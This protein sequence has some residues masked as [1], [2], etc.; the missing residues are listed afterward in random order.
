MSNRPGARRYVRTAS[1]NS[2]ASRGVVFVLPGIMG[3]QLWDLGS[4]P[5]R[6][7]IEPKHI[8]GGR[9]A[10]LELDSTGTDDAQSGVRI[11]SNGVI[12]G[13][14]GTL[15]R[16]LNQNDF[17][18]CAFD[19]DWR[20]DLDTLAGRLAEAVES[21]GN[22]VPI[23]I[24]AH[25]MGGLVV[26]TV[27]ATRPA[28]ASRIQRLVM[29]GT[30]NF[31][32]Y[33][34][35]Q[36]FTGQHTFTKLVAG[37]DL[38]NRREDLIRYFATFPGLVAMLPNPDRTE[39]GQPQFFAAAT[40]PE[41]NLSQARLDR[42][43]AEQRRLDS[44]MPWRDRYTLIVGADRR[45]PARAR[46]NG[47]RGFDFD[48]RD[49]DG[50]VPTSLCL[51]PGV[52]ATHFTRAEH[53]AMPSDRTVI[54][55]I[56][57]VLSGSQVR[58]ARSAGI[59]RVAIG[60]Q[61]HSEP[62]I[63]IPDFI[64]ECRARVPRPR[65][66]RAT[67][68]TATIDGD[69]VDAIASS[70]TSD[71]EK[72][73]EA[74]TEE[75]LRSFVMQAPTVRTPRAR[76][77]APVKVEGIAQRR[78]LLVRSCLGSIVD[79]P[80]ATLALGVFPGQVPTGAL[81]ALDEALDGY[82]TELFQQGGIRGGLGEVTFL[83]MPAARVRAEMALLVG[84]GDP[85]SFGPEALARAGHA[86]ARALSHAR[87]G[88][89]A[90]VVIGSGNQAAPDPSLRGLL[91]GFLAGLE[92]ADPDHLFRAVSFFEVDRPRL[93]R[94]RNE[95]EVGAEYW[96]QRGLDLEV[97]ELPDSTIPAK[98]VRGARELGYWIDLD[99]ERVRYF[100]MG[101]AANPEVVRPGGLDQLDAAVLE[102]QAAMESELTHARKARALQRFGRDLAKSFPDALAEPL[103]G[104][105][106]SDPAVLHLS[107]SAALVPWELMPL[108]DRAVS[109]RLP[110]VRRL[111]IG[112]DHRPA[113][114][115]QLEHEWSHRPRVAIVADPTDDLPGAR[116]EGKGLVAALGASRQF[117]VTSFIG[118]AEVDESRL[119]DMLDSG[120]VDVLHYAGH[121]VFDPLRPERSGLVVHGGGDGILTAAEVSRCRR[122]PVLVFANACQVGIVPPR[123][124]LS[125][126]V[127]RDLRAR[128]PQGFAEALLA[129]GVRGYVGTFWSIPDDA[130][131]VFAQQFYAEVAQ[132]RP[133]GAALLAARQ[134]TRE[135]RIASGTWAWA[136][137]MLY[138]PAWL[139]L[140]GGP[141]PVRGRPRTR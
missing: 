5:C 55:A 116:A 110:M 117:E 68:R 93:A 25:S 29:L 89:L 56:V 124:A 80:S 129:A 121:G 33:V 128:Q 114:A 75:A 70:L 41:S 32:S 138:G 51:L 21:I 39:D 111:S 37:L 135:A 112:A 72:A 12:G 19:F 40:W 125:K 18:A 88:D 22:D 8:V 35:V 60:L 137:Y 92:V 84:L 15:V 23:Q 26:R 13:Y 47:K 77:G 50:T 87:I 58:L 73:L 94:L 76:K 46:R 139:E 62:E 65:S 10:R 99:A 74:C 136:S 64:G 66:G 83:P 120:S 7:W 71:Q 131:V 63:A 106:Q 36:V 123:E 54:N 127:G 140:G 38:R 133:L 79:A 132:G 130:A 52:A 86:L 104:A 2:K 115:Y 16:N 9:L 97:R 82:I 6:I 85:V 101:S 100:F 31:G 134:A 4:N 69:E 49:G 53:G 113:A 102:L 11:R 20:R 98:V 78:R 141:E 1:R 14:Y 126:P 103:R 27:F 61:P 45:T 48:A 59:S 122:P 3:S 67:T 28:A 105:R 118:S 91:T 57:S 43:R 119:H 95:V 107:S 81:A 44:D 90:T 17:A 24:V 108:D 42:A 34:P 96:R 30:P 109:L